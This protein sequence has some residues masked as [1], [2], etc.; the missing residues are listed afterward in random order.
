MMEK[1]RRR[2]EAVTRR[3]RDF[4]SLSLFF[5]AFSLSLPLFC[6]SN[7]SVRSCVLPKP[8]MDRWMMMREFFFPLPCA[9]MSIR[10][11]DF[12]EGRVFC[13]DGKVLLE[14]GLQL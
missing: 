14:G 11:G 7:V 10:E 2:R 13:H 5:P 6:R 1:M 12:G 8:S 3:C 9:Y 4:L